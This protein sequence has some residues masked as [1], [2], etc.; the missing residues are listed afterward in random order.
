VTDI[1]TEI[2]STQVRF[3]DTLTNRGANEQEFQI[4]YHSN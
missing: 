1:S 3:D 4:I 2:G